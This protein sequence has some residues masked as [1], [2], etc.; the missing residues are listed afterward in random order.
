MEYESIKKLINDVGNS[1][2]ASLEIDF[3]DGTK[4][5]MIKECGDTRTSEYGENAIKE[6]SNT[7][8]QIVEQPSQE[9]INQEQIY[10]YIKSMFI[11]SVEM[12]KCFYYNIH[13]NFPTTYLIFK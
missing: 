12:F 2:I 4:I 7:T 9:E 8:K 5:S 13:K 10:K 1:K 11:N 3:P 6:Y